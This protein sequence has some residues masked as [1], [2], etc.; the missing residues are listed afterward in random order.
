MYLDF[1]IVF[2]CYRNYTLKVQ[3][4]QVIFGLFVL[5]LYMNMYVRVNPDAD[6]CCCTAS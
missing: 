2:D 3:F 1:D 4:F 5:I 6:L